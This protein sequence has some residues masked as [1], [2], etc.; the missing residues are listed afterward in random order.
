MA[1]KPP[2]NLKKAQS[3]ELQ[4]EKVDTSQ[5]NLVWNQIAEKQHLIHR[6]DRRSSQVSATADFLAKSKDGS[7]LFELTQRISPSYNCEFW[8]ITESREVQVKREH[9]DKCT[10]WE[11]DHDLKLAPRG[12]A[13]KSDEEFVEELV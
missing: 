3:A 5:G 9:Y 10:Y 6:M 4:K 2:K 11:M 8:L 7:V 1:R 12:R 13:K